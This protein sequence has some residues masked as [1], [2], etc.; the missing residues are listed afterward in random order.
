MAEEKITAQETPKKKTARNTGKRKGEHRRY[1]D[2]YR[3]ELLEK[4]HTYIDKN[5]NPTLAGFCMERDR[6]NKDT[7]YEWAKSD[8]RYGEAIDRAIMKVEWYRLSGYSG[9]PSVDI[10]ILKQP[11]HGYTDKQEFAHTGANGGPVILQWGTPTI[12]SKNK[13]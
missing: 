12:S 1:T 8:W 9:N 2:K 10:F 13:E 5:H 11:S 6:P 4:F 7:L 3:N